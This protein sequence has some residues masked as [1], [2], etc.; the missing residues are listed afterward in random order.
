MYVSSVVNCTS[1]F[2]RSSRMLDCL[3]VAA[4][5]NMLVPNPPFYSPS[6][7]S[8]FSASPSYSSRLTRYRT[9]R[10]LLGNVLVAPFSLCTRRRR[11]HRHPHRHLTRHCTHRAFLI[12]HSPP[13]S[14]SPS[15][16]TSYSPLYSSRLTRQHPSVDTRRGAVTNS[17]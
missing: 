11:P 5:L 14:A 4:I 12:M 6:Y 10:V 17:I 15:S 7:S 9:R 16:S 13:A 1:P 2:S 8:S 3:L